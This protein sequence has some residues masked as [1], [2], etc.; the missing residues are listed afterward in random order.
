MLPTASRSAHVVY[1]GPDRKRDLPQQRGSVGG[2]VLDLSRA[3]F[4][5]EGIRRGYTFEVI[6]EHPLH[7]FRVLRGGIGFIFQFWPGFLSRRRR[8]DFPQ[9]FDKV[10]QKRLLER[11]NLPAPTLFDTVR[12]P[13]ELRLSKVKLPAVTKPRNGTYSR[14]V[15]THINS[16][17]ALVA[18]VTEISSAGLQTLIEEHVDG[19]HYRL[20]CV[21]G[22][23]VGCVERRA[24]NVTGDGIHTIRELID[25]RNREP[26]RGS[27]RNILRLLHFLEFDSTSAEILKARGV[28]FDTVLPE[29]QMLTIQRKITGAVGADFIGV[30]HRVHPETI[31]ACEAFATTHDLFMAGFDFITPDIERP[32]TEVGVFN[33]VNVRNV[34]TSCIEHCNMGEQTP[35][36][37]YIWDNIPF[38][39]ISEHWFPIF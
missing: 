11:S 9:L 38:E 5:R 19:L 31:A 23:F 36:S 27:K 6:Y 25:I 28:Y 35:V 32:F 34:D 2:A 24:P 18:A 29:G 21:R 16:M 20:L 22:S 12:A 14:Y 17:D 33:E 39:E 30:T 4:L 10:H 1:G 37:R 13:S 8:P 15:T 7:I 3:S 26:G